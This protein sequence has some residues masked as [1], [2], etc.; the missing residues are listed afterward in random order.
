MNVGES[1]TAT[2][3]TTDVHAIGIAAMLAHGAAGIHVVSGFRFD[4]KCARSDWRRR[5]ALWAWNARKWV[6][7]AESALRMHSIRPATEHAHFTLR[8]PVVWDVGMLRKLATARRARNVEEVSRATEATLQVLSVSIAAE[9]A[10]LAIR[11]PIVT[12]TEW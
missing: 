5:C 2:E 3:T 1:A 6:I 9:V 8:I 11:I 7:T 12:N 10:H 4:C